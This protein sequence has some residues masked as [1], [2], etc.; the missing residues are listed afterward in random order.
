M[1]AGSELKQQMRSVQAISKI[2]KAMELVSTAKLKKL[3]R[4]IS[5]SQVYFQEVYD[6]LQDVINAVEQTIYNWNETSATA[7]SCFIVITSNLGL[8]GGYNLNITKILAKELQKDDYLIVFGQK[9]L[10]FCEH[11]KLTVAEAY[12]DFNHDATY[13]NVQRISNEIL[14]KFQQRSFQKINLIYT[15]FHNNVTFEPT[16]LTLLPIKKQVATNLRLK[17]ETEFEPNAST[18]L[19]LALPL[20]L[21]AIIYSALLESQL[22]EYASRRNAMENATK[23]A[24]EMIEKLSLAYNRKRQ[25]SIT[26]EILEII[27]GA[28]AQQ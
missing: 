22:S 15:K 20:Y 7:R 3:S 12:S 9:G 17:S 13:D 28:N 1:A 21:S 14:A 26:Q 2:T 25:A 16:L 5:H 27:A 23:N 8:C 11:Q 10:N 6:I 4:T 24:N 18:V 19:S